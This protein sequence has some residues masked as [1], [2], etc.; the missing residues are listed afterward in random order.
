MNNSLNNKGFTLVEILV[1][2][3]V[4]TLILAGVF[5]SF[6]DLTNSSNDLFI[7]ESIHDDSESLL[8]IIGYELRMIGNGIPFDQENF[9]V[10]DNL[11]NSLQVEV[12]QDSL[13]NY[14]SHPLLTD[15][16]T[17]SFIEFR[18]NETGNVYFITANF[19]PTTSSVISVSDVTGLL[20]GDDIYLSNA[21]RQQDDGMYAKVSA[22]NTSSNEITIE[23]DYYRSIG[24]SFDKGC[25][26]EPVNL[27][28]IGESLGNI[29]RNSGF[30]DIVLAK[31]ASIEFDYLDKDGISL[32]LPLSESDLLSNLGAI[33][34]SITLESSKKQKVLGTQYDT[35]SLT[36]SQVFGL[37]SF[38]F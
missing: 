31:N 6:S 36:K 27:V 14:P 38:N 1:S 5:S 33:E 26:I 3:F 8:N 20:V 35:Y 18:I 34:V 32:T 19:D 23:S 37:R 30:G 7:R 2:M 28:T 12:V 22:I 29:T 11:E 10:N 17:S 25:T 21:I 13:N 24:A 15:T 16:S 4:M 9:K